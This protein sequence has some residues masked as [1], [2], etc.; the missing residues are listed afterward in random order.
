MSTP[1]E[2]ARRRRM[3]KIKARANKQEEMS[4]LLLSGDAGKLNQ[5]P[6]EIKLVEPIESFETSNMQNTDEMSYSNTNQT[7]EEN[8]EGKN[9]EEEMDV[10]EQR[11]Y[12]K[13]LENQRI[14]YLKSKSFL[15]IFMSLVSGFWLAHS[16]AKDHSNFF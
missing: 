10:W 2:E 1:A 9:Q 15:I 16:G 4:S 11:R 12:L 3:E 7:P 5:K 13:N 8:T 6:E 14:F